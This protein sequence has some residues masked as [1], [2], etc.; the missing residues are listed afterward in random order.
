MRREQTP[1]DLGEE[2]SRQGEQAGT[3]SGVPGPMRRA[4]CWGSSQWAC[5]HGESRRGPEGPCSHRSTRSRLLRLRN[6][7]F[8]TRR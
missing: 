1:Q 7:V 5:G 6:A 2:S 4:V 3:D 8:I